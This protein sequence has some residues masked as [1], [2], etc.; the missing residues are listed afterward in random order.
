MSGY[1]E[2]L[3]AAAMELDE[4]GLVSLVCQ[5]GYMLDTRGGRLSAKEL[6][7]CIAASREDT[8]RRAAMRQQ[9]SVPPNASV[10]SDSQT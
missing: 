5:L 10:W 4:L 2:E 3:H 7:V 1:Q 9:L 6:A 8:L